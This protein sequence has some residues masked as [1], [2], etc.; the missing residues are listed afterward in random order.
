MIT[1]EKND[2]I[3]NSFMMWLVDELQKEI[4]AT[5]NLNK[6]QK[7]TSESKY[8]LGN[9]VNIEEA[10]IYLVINLKLKHRKDIFLTAFYKIIL[11]CFN[12]LPEKNYLHTN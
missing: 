7:L 5:S 2:K 12:I 6:L 8:Q 10:F 3:T 11:F 4:I 1:I 9:Y